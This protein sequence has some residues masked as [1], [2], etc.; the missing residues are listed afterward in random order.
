MQ[1][2]RHLIIGD[3]LRGYMGAPII[4]FIFTLTFGSAAALIVH[5]VLRKIV[6]FRAEWNTTL[7]A[8]MMT[9]LV[10]CFG[11][12]CASAIFGDTSEF[13]GLKV[14]GSAALI[15]MFGGTLACRLI[16]R[17]ES[18][19][20]LPT[21]GAAFLA[22]LLGVPPTAAGMVILFFFTEV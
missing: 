8:C 4:L 3:Y 20:S 1:N 16:I 18:G 13:R 7:I 19:R 15:S 6:R 10:C 22:F 14:I 9:V 11:F 12:I 5:K 21:S 17:S 2:A